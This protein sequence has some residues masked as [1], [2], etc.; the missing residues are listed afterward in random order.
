MNVSN[1]RIG[2]RL[3]ASYGLLLVLM[4]LL[5]GAGAWLLRD[6]DAASQRILHDA[7]PK[8]RLVTEWRSAIVLNA[9]RTALALATED[10]AERSAA[11]AGMRQTSERISAIMKELDRT[12]TSNAGKRLLATILATRAQY[13]EVRKALLAADAAGDAAAIADGKARLA[14]A[15]GAYDTGLAALAGHEREQAGKMEA[16]IAAESH[17]GQ[18]LLGVLCTVALLIACASTVLVTRS[19]T[20]PLRRAVEVA[21]TVAAGDLSSV[22]AAE[23]KD[24]TGQ[25]LGALRDMNA[26]LRAIVGEV[27]G[28]AETIATAS[29]EIATGNLDLSSRTEQQ[30]GSLEET[31]SSME[32]LTSTVRQNAENARQAN[33]LALQAS[34]VAERGGEVI[35]GVTT[36]MGAIRASADK[37]V[38][39]I[40]VIDSI[41]FQ[42][43]IL[44]LNAA[45]EAARAGEQG[46]GFAVV[47]SEVR[48]LAQRSANAAKEIKG[49]IDASVANVGAGSRQ[50]EQA[51]ATMDEIVRSVARV[52]DIMGEITMASR[53]QET[54]IEQINGAVAEM[55]TVTQ[56]NAALVEEAAAAAQSLQ[57]QS[58]RLAEAVSVFRLE[59]T[60][61]GRGG[62]RQQTSEVRALAL[63]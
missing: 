10:A 6:F 1:L 28:G 12:V 31:A 55:D 24:E 61:Q 43:N 49:L 19:I 53:E 29:S 38:D 25:L 14:T 42:T 17:R 21:R 15:L 13:S 51:G 39:I 7:I 4:I 18:L 30:A 35:A 58:A 63:A 60:A 20:R 9:N 56:Q 50:V 46:R 48:T 27:R 22:I 34:H 11:E 54:G 2:A 8:E 44:A 45:V 36:T 40:G 32:E 62:W 16:A 26:S 33:Q 37:I 41:A 23:S 59:G 47:A 52:T 57:E 5:T 3:G